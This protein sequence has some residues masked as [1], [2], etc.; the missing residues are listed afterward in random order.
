MP[1]SSKSQK[2]KRGFDKLSPNGLL[3]IRGCFPGL[4]AGWHYLD[5]AATAQKPQVVIDAMARAM[6][7][8][9]ATVH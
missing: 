7:E 4:P 6:G 5:T 1:C 9:Y 2:E 3:D 8:D